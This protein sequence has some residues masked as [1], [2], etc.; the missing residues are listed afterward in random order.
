MRTFV[1]LL[2]IAAAAGCGTDATVSGVF[3]AEGFSGRTLRVEIS[4]DATEW[5]GSPGVNFGQ[6]VTVSNV[7]VASPTSLFADITIADDATPGTRDVTITNDGTFTLKSSFMIES[8]MEL[9]FDGM[10]AQGGAP[11][12]TINNRD[13]ETPF[14]LTSGDTPSGFANLT[15]TSPAG[16]QFVISDS[17]A[18]QLK[19]FALID[20]DAMPG[21]LSVS[22]GTMGHE[23]AFN[24]GANVDI[25]A[26]APMALTD[27][28]TG[29]LAATG[30]SALYSVNVATSPALMRVVATTSDADGQPVTAMLPNGQWADATGAA[31]SVVNATGNVDVVVFDAGTAGGYSYTLKSKVEQLTSGAEAT[32]ANDTPAASLNASALPFVQTGGTVSAMA[33]KDVIKI[34][35]SAPAVVHVAAHSGD[36]LT[37]TAVDILANGS[38]NPSVL[39]NYTTKPVDEAGCFPLFGLGCGEDVT[40]PMLAAGTYFIVISAG[41]AFD[42]AD[43]SYTALIYLN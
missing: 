2:V 10:V 37:D 16:T 21:P 38:G 22:S 33:D 26:R 15:L 20:A 34:V 25:T 13:F 19:G 27:S 32:T 40:S 39:T 29:M 28:A 31:L 3:P 23:V 7:T 42:V 36:D 6:G 9:V 5:S 14:D 30:D 1:S 4:G 24:L 43:N 8:P 41:G 17:T 35:L 18:Y 11:Y 12:F